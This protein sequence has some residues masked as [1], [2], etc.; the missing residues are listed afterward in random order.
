MGWVEEGKGWKEDE[1]IMG[2]GWE[3]KEMGWESYLYSLKPEKLE[4]LIVESA[5]GLQLLEKRD[6]HARVVLVWTGKVDVLEIKDET[7]AIAR[8][9]HPPFGGTEQ[10]TNLGN[11]LLADI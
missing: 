6:K 3:R 1:K 4:V 9:V 7:L 5:E 11:L 8:S 10:A 2:R